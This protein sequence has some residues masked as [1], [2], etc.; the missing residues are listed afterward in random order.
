VKQIARRLILPG[1]LLTVSCAAVDASEQGDAEFP[2]AG[3]STGA[4]DEHGSLPSVESDDTAAAEGIVESPLPDVAAIRSDGSVV[5]VRDG[6]VVG[7]RASGN[8]S[9]LVGIDGRTL[10]EAISGGADAT[11]IRWTHLFTGESAGVASI[12]GSQLAPTVTD[13]SGRYV[14]LVSEAAEQRDGA[15]APGRASST[16]V[17]A[18]R[19]LGER[20]RTTLPGNFYPEAFGITDTPTGEPDTI[21]LLEYLPAD[22]PTHYRVRVLHRAT[23]EIGL[24]V[25]L[26]FKAQEVDAEMAGIS[27][28]QVVSGHDGG[29]VF[30]L[31]R[32]V[33]G[34]GD[35]H[36]YA[37]VHTLGLAGGVWCLDI[38]PEMELGAQAGALVVAGDRLVVASANG[39]IGNY[40]IAA[41]PDPTR[42]P[43]MDVVR[44]YPHPEGEPVLAAT[45]DRV[46][47]AWGD[48]LYELDA[49][50]LELVAF[51][52]RRV[53][54]TVSALGATDDGLVIAYADGTIALRDGVSIDVTPGND[55]DDAAGIDDCREF[56][57]LGQ[58]DDSVI[59]GAAILSSPREAYGVIRHPPRTHSFTL[60]ATNHDILFTEPQQHLFVASSFDTYK[61]V[62]DQCLETYG[63][64]V[65]AAPQ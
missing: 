45:D 40:E 46:W 44:D 31:Y 34:E 62:L 20:Y 55:D 47:V 37:F 23:G 12:H 3:A 22:A 36:G 19:E 50:T 59:V 32:G 60:D 18:D 41:V 35:R 9:R 6:H 5:W 63:S 14:A 21:Y 64:A 28:T 58:P 2:P 57:L 33:A 54:G 39:T 48:L 1:I 16:I 8:A 13:T 25:N 15:I 51:E 27:R 42:Q 11:E 4:A 52:P 38:A 61:D 56:G 26:R 49:T 24:P 7:R 29:L 30:T 43:V 10:I 65:P 17:I 53:A